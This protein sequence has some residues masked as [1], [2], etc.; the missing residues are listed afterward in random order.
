MSPEPTR[1]FELNDD[2]GLE[3]SHLRQKD[4]TEVENPRA[5]QKAP[6][7]NVGFPVQYPV[8]VD[9]GELITRTDIVRVEPSEQ[10]HPQLKTR[11]IPGTRIVE[12]ANS[13]VAN[14]LLESNYHEV[15]APKSEQGR[16][17]KQ[18]KSDA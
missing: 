6:L 9:G 17:T 3:S 4:G 13:Q 14:T 15:D 12:T 16:T 1:F 8:K 2:V 11:V 10:L 5:G 18:E 7:N